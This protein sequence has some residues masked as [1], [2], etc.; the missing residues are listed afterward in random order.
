MCKPSALRSQVPDTTNKITGLGSIFPIG[1]VVKTGPAPSKIS[2]EVLSGQIIQG[3]S[4]R[5]LV[6]QIFK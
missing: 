1:K 5:L 3:I 4:P 2:Q 6:G